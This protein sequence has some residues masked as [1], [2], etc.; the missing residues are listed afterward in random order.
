MS[1]ASF[2]KSSDLYSIELLIAGT[3]SFFIFSHVFSGRQLLR[4]AHPDCKL[5]NYKGLHTFDAQI[6]LAGLL[7]FQVYRATSISICASAMNRDGKY[8]PVAINPTR[9]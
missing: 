4:G 6:Q 9:R 8:F 1:L 5:S 2:S 7:H 3:E